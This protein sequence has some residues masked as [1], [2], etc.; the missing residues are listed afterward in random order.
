M[1]EAEFHC[2]SVSQGRRSCQVVRSDTGKDIVACW[3]GTGMIQMGWECER[4]CRI[5]VK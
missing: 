2:I 3:Q 4:T 5:A 1:Y